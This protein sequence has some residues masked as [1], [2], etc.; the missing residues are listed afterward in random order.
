MSH[1]PVQAAIQEARDDRKAAE[2]DAKSAAAEVERLSAEVDEARSTLAATREAPETP[3]AETLRS[4]IARLRTET[5]STGL[6]LDKYRVAAAKN[7][8]LTLAERLQGDDR[9]ALEADAQAF[10]PFLQAGPPPFMGT[11]SEEH[12]R[13][14]ADLF[15][16]GHSR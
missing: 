11:A 8:P 9:E 13:L 4:E 12:A 14:V 10:A 1:D 2:A 7:L 6:L 15:G 16:P 5:A 3:E